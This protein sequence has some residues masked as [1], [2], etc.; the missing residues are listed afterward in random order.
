[1][2]PDDIFIRA[3]ATNRGRDPATLHFL[4]T[5]WFRNTW[6]WGRDDRRPNLL[7]GRN[8]EKNVAVIEA[9]HDL[10]GEYR[11]FCEERGRSSLHRK[12]NQR[13]TSVGRA[14]P[15]P[16]REGLFQRFVVRGQKESVNPA[17][18]GQKRPRIIAFHSA[19]AKRV[20]FG[21]ACDESSLGRNSA[22]R[23]FAE[24]RRMLLRNGARE[25]DEFYE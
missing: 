3:T 9:S 4:P 19:P 15:E 18:T 12:R 6:S 22:S 23:R 20:S 5:I 17:R 13:R 21:C 7:A 2:E 10:L 11:L 1:M 24:F 16:V 14:E 8:A 25:A